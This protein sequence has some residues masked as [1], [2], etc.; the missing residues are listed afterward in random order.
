MIQELKYTLFTISIITSAYSW[1][2][3]TSG[4]GY[5]MINNDK[6]KIWCIGRYAVEVPAEARFYEQLDHYDSFKIETLNK[7]A[8]RADFDQAVAK[9][10]KIYTGGDAVVVNDFPVVQGSESSVSKIILGNLDPSISKVVHVRAFVLDKGFLFSIE[11]KYSPKFENESKEAIQNLVKNLKMR[12]DNMIPKEKGFCI[13]NGFI[14]DGGSKYRYTSQRLILDFPQYPSVDIS[15]ESESVYEN[16]GGLMKRTQNNLKEQGVLSKVFSNIKT[17]RKGSKKINQFDGEE[18]LVSAPMK[19]KNGI[20]AI[21]AYSGIANNNLYPSFQLNLT[22]G[23]DSGTHSA[24]IS[25]FEAERMYS[26]ILK[27][28]RLF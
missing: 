3:S 24:S 25:N 1:A 21:W 27:S 22:N 15:F 8:S 6:K 9:S 14:I 11:G 23:R 2:D 19:G 18:W 26:E 5:T 13:K 16:D 12:Q 7:K 10:L 20:D 28:I 17:V 4:E